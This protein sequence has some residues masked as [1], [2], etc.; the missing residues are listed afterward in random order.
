[1]DQVVSFGGVDTT[2]R[3]VTGQVDGFREGKQN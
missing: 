2:L 3:V 1:M